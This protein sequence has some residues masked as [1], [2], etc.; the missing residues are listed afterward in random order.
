VNFTGNNNIVIEWRVLYE[1]IAKVFWDFQ[2]ERN[3]ILLH[4]LHAES[5]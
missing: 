2:T 5:G 3:C 1:V 4:V